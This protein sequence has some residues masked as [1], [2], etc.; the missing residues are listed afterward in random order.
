MKKCTAV[1]FL[2][3]VSVFC[4]A[5]FA[6][7][8]TTPAFIKPQFLQAS[9]KSAGIASEYILSSDADYSRSLY[10]PSLKG[11]S[12]TIGFPAAGLLPG[13][14]FLLEID[15]VTALVTFTRDRKLGVVSGDSRIENVE[16]FGTVGCILTSVFGMVEDILNNVSELNIFGIVAAVFTGVMNILGCL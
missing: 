15:G 8:G 4:S 16:A 13:R 12:V 5:Q 7:A 6:H 14:P 9:L 10:I 2:L 11:S 3:F 1:L